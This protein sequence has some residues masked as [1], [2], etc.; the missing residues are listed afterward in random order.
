MQKVVLA[1]REVGDPFLGQVR[2]RLTYL[3]V[4]CYFFHSQTF[5]SRPLKPLNLLNQMLYNKLTP[6]DILGF[7]LALLRDETIL[8]PSHLADLLIATH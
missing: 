8:A 5:F 2:S 6:H 3:V 7:F 4:V 1:I